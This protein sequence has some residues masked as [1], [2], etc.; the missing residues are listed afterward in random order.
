MEEYF[1]GMLERDLCSSASDRLR[2]LFMVKGEYGCTKV[3]NLNSISLSQVFQYVQGQG[4]YVQGKRAGCE[5]LELQ[6]E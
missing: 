4:K 1:P 6:Y 3:Y 2:S 5:E